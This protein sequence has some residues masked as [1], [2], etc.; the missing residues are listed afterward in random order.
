MNVP[1]DACAR[2]IS[3]IQN[4]LMDADSHFVRERLSVGQ[5]SWAHVAY[6]ADQQAPA[7]VEKLLQRSLPDEVARVWGAGGYVN[8]NLSL[9]YFQ[10]HLGAYIDAL[11]AYTPSDDIPEDALFS[12]IPFVISRLNSAKRHGGIVTCPDDEAACEALWRLF[13]LNSYL[14]G[15]KLRNKTQSLC[16]TLLLLTSNLP[17]DKRV[18]RLRELYGILEASSRGIGCI[19]EYYLKETAQGKMVVNG[20]P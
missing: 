16:K 13:A 19:W 4:L 9:R 18:S 3:L 1:Y 10:S 5:P 7:L 11:P 20:R 14:S 15:S 12:S 17:S 6:F 8:V 2:G